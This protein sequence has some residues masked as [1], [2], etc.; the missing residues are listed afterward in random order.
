MSVIK[1]ILCSLREGERDHSLFYLEIFS[2]YLLKSKF[3]MVMKLGMQKW[4]F[5]FTCESAVMNT[6]HNY[7]YLKIMKYCMVD[8]LKTAFL[9]GDQKPY[10]ATCTVDEKKKK[11]P[12]Y[13][14]TNYRTK[15]ELVRIIMD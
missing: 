10:F 1:K 9:W 5:V 12:I 14:N 3:Y 13:F 2:R 11:I 15:M 4:L 8:K 7:D 6:T